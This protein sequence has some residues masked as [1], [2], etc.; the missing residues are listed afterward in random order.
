MK[1]LFK[2]LIP[3]VKRHKLFF[4]FVN[5]TSIAIA[6]TQTLFP[7]QV[8]RLVDKA[9]ATNDKND[10]YFGILILTGLA[11]MDLMFNI[12]QRLSATRFGQRIIEDIRN[13]LYQ[14]LQYQE[15]EFYAFES[16][17]QIMSRTIEE[18]MSLSDV[19]RWA[20]RITLLLVWLLIGSVIAMWGV[21]PYMSLIFIISLT[22]P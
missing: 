10:L 14:T 11:L 20:Y 12:L 19:L 9:I 1:Q 4:F 17:G 7:L 13:D 22:S 16:V 6:A 18:V 3:Y 2:M 8:G 21:S 15:M 5:I